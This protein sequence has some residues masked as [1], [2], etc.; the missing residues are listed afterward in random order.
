MGMGSFLL[1]DVIISKYYSFEEISWWAFVKSALA[2]ASTI[3]IVGVDQAIIRHP[4]GLGVALK[5]LLPRALIISILISTGLAC[6]GGSPGFVYWLICILLLASLSVFGAILRGAYKMNAAQL[7]LNGW[8]LLLLALTLSSVYFSLG[9]T[10]EWS[11]MLAL[12]TFA[13]GFSGYTLLIEGWR[14]FYREKVIEEGVI[15]RKIIMTDAKNFFVLTLSLSASINFEQLGLNFLGYE[16][17]SAILL[18]HASIYLPFVVFLN[19]FIGFYL[20]PYIRK[21]IHNM[22][23]KNFGRINLVFI[24][25]GVLLSFFSTLLGSVAFDKFYGNKYELDLL[26]AILLVTS[27]FAR[28]LYS[29]P[30]SF[31][32]VVSVSVDLKRFAFGNL[33]FLFLSVMLFGVFV[34]SSF[35]SAI[36]AILLCSVMNWVL[37]VGYGYFLVYK[38]LREK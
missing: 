22:R 20:A 11:V 5:Y 2:L 13:I 17:E 33:A 30:S 27:G 38:N 29:I 10:L 9:P 3:C 31:I 25:V 18:A 8:K 34:L 4:S 15:P 26:V 23:S 32:G 19:G 6:I 28:Y 14:K 36:I 1:L 24:F 7:S 16:R 12:G 37:R 35:T 21:N